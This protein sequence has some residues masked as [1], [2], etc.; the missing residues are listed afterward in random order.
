ML[1]GLNGFKGVGKDTVGQILVEQYDYERLAFADKVK[2]VASALFDLQ[3]ATAWDFHKNER[4]S[5]IELNFNGGTRRTFT[6]RHFLQRIGT[7]M[8]RNVFGQDFWVDLVLPSESDYDGRNI[9]VTDARFDNELRRIKELGGYNVR[10]LRSGF[11]GDNHASEQKPDVR[12]IDY[13]IHN[14]G[15]F[16]DLRDEVDT[17]IVAINDAN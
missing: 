6:V 12:L 3:P 11:D 16:E 14:D 4:H 9:V 10:I 8:G 2:E 17:T 13:F 7:E 15:S 1:I 5:V